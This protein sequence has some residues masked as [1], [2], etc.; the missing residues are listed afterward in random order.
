M[1]RSATLQGPSSQDQYGFRSGNRAVH[2]ERICSVAGLA[3]VLTAALIVLL[4]TVPPLQDFQEWMFQ[5]WVL[6][7]LISGHQQVQSIARLSPVPIPNSTV[8]VLLGV[9]NFGVSPVAAGRIAVLLYLALGYVVILRIS[10]RGPLRLHGSLELLL[11]LSL[12]LSSRFWNGYLAYQTGLWM[13]GGFLLYSHRLTAP[14]AWSWKRVGLV[15]VAGVAIYLTHLAAYAGFLIAC[16]FLMVRARNFRVL[17]AATPSALLG[18]WYVLGMSRPAPGAPQTPM[19]WLVHLMEYKVYTAGKWGPFVNFYE[20]PKQ[21][22]LG[23]YPLL[24]W[25]GVGLNLL[26][27]VGLVVLLF[28]V[29]AR[30]WRRLWRTAPVSTGVCALCLAAFVLLPTSDRTLARFSGVQAGVVNLGERV[31]GVGLLAGLVAMAESGVLRSKPVRTLAFLAML[32]SFYLLVPAFFLP[33]HRASRIDFGDVVTEYYTNQR[34]FNTRPYQ[35]I[36][37]FDFLR[38]PEPRGPVPKL[39]FPTG[40]LIPPPKA[41]TDPVAP[42]T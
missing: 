3:V 8:Q 27:G 9:L 40:P 19:H 35:F 38:S 14:S 21:S 5:G 32:G 4:H 31:L 7:E 37:R 10:H 34:Y 39:I 11:V 23:A 36:R 20:A 6:K 22:A 1:N 18:A 12:L 28:W 41:T 24:Y 15:A 30:N 16:A 17:L 13:F 33:P 2:W 26:F 29:V 25:A 42:G